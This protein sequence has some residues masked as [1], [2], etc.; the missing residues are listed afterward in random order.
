MIKYSSP[1][2]G[3]ERVKETLLEAYAETDREIDK[4]T[5]WIA[6]PGTDHLDSAQSYHEWIKKFR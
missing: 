2:P 4:L 3:D 1:Q 5:S 6:E